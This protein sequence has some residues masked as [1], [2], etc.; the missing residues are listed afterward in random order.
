MRSCEPRSHGGRGVEEMVAWGVAQRSGKSQI[1]AIGLFSSRKI[2]RRPLQKRERLGSA[3]ISYASFICNPITS[4]NIITP[5]QRQMTATRYQISQD[6]QSS[7]RNDVPCHRMKLILLLIEETLPDLPIELAD[8]PLHMERLLEN[9]RN[10]W[11]KWGRGL[12]EMYSNRIQPRLAQRSLTLFAINGSDW[13]VRNA[14]WLIRP[15][16]RPGH[17]PWHQLPGNAP[18]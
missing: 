18:L 14:G 15:A 7:R 16:A 9:G 10:G 8:K 2:P 3:C 1:T 17:L 4:H 6:S 11:V 13:L 5:V 12:G